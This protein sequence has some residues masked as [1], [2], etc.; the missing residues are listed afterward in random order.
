MTKPSF[1]DYGT[2]DESAYPEL[3]DG[4]VGAWCPSLGPTGLR[5]HDHSRRSIWGTMTNADPATCWAVNSGQYS[6]ALDG[7]NDYVTTADAPFD[8]TDKFAIAFWCNI[9]SG[10]MLL[11]KGNMGETGYGFDF[12]GFTAGQIE[13]LT[14]QN[15]ATYINR[16]FANPG[17][18]VHVCGMFDSSI[19]GTGR[20]ILYINGVQRAG[21]VTNAGTVTAVSA[22][23]NNLLLGSYSTLN[24]FL[25]GAL[26]DIRI[27]SRVLPDAQIKLL[28]SERGIAYARRRRTLR[29]LAIG[30]GAA[31]KA[32]WA[33]RQN[34]IIGGGV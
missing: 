1:Q 32:Y 28:A 5:L 14:L 24:L 11:T 20:N 10:R 29:R 15:G 18:W 12:G 7:T 6:L 25:N 4:V 13:W 17:G 26:D 23:N 33:R 9:T 8:L 19:A 21:T 30:E 27:Y 2:F 34:Q 3:W 22:N 16:G 31:F